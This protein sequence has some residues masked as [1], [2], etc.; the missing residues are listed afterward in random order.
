MIEQDLL[1]EAVSRLQEMLQPVVTVMPLQVAVPEPNLSATAPPSGVDA[2]LTLS[3]SGGGGYGRLIVEAKQDVA[4]VQARTVLADKINLM[5]QLNGEASALIVAPW[6]SPRTRAELRERGIGYLD[7]SGNVWLRMHRPVV[8]IDKEGQQQDP[9]PRRRT[10]TAQ[11]AGAKAGRLVRFLVDFRP[12]YRAL[13]V[14]NG[15]GLSQPYVSRL[16]DALDD[17]ALIT[18]K[19]RQIVDVDWSELLRARAERAG[20]LKVNA[21]SYWLAPQGADAVLASLRQWKDAE[22]LGPVAVTGSMAAEQLVPLSIGG[23]LMLYA[24]ESEQVAANLQLLGPRPSGGDVVLLAPADPV[25]F[26]RTRKDGG[27]TYVG[28][29]QLALDLL[30]GTGRMPAEGEALLEYMRAND[31][32]WRSDYEPET[33]PRNAS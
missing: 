30:G 17:Q 29:S 8:L 18:R 21:A 13:D 28:L 4:P 31:D 7:L 19:Q 20:L 32:Q 2:I 5:R 22:D 1:S 6:L 27:L 24:P 23:Q 10:G 33:G 25:A 3:D 11:L 14:A 12:P 15:T 9:R 26:E 16:L